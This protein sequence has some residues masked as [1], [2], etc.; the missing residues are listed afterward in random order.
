[1]ATLI[2]G[3][4]VYTLTMNTY[5][6]QP[7]NFSDYRDFLKK[8]YEQLKVDNP[9]F[10]LNACAI[11]SKISKSLLQFIFRKKR[12]LGLDKMPALAKALKLTSHEEYFIYLMICKNSSKNIEIQNHFENILN[13]L[14]H[15][16]VKVATTEPTRANTNNKNLYLDYLFM[17]I[18]TLV[19]LDD[20]QEDPKWILKNLNVPNLTETK[21]TEVL[22]DLE[23]QKFLVR[24][25]N[26]K[27]K[28]PQETLW[29]PDPYDPSGQKVFTK[30]AECMA[31][32][33]QKPELYKP[34][35]YM[36]MSLAFDEKN[37]LQAEKLMI[38][39]HHQLSKLAKD[40]VQP[41]AVTQFGNFM[42]TVSRIKPD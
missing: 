12:H 10:S 4:I 31:E 37:L 27:L 34:S 30:G 8:R 6:L 9:K 35:V 20:F 36:S 3:K 28:A 11:K 5:T 41:T 39:L 14:R 1:M 16:S 22:K 17:M 19:R 21:I 26:K 2:F 42:L 15:E 24:D 25:E 40:S 33:M 29:R 32:L 13:R 38:E 18:Q 23:K 7:A